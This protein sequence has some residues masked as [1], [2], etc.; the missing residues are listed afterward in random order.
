MDIW[1]KSE[2]DWTL[3][4]EGHQLIDKDEH[5]DIMGCYTEGCK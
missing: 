2:E 1:V 3:S 5:K 4:L